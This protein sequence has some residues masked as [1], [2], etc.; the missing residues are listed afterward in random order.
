MAKLTD[1]QMVFWAERFTAELAGLCTEDKI[2]LLEY[3][4][5]VQKAKL[6]RGS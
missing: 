5:K 4:L 6:T 3:L 1:K 2:R